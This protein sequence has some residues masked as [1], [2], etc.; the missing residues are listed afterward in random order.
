MD[1]IAVRLRAATLGL[2]TGIVIVPGKRIELVLNGDGIFEK[3]WGTSA[4]RRTSCRFGWTSHGRGD[5]RTAGA[6]S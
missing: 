3:V 5:S 6:R 1:I 4:R 2:L